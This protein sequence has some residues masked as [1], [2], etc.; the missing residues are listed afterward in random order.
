MEDGAD[1][2]PRASAEHRM[3]NRRCAELATGAAAAE[4]EEEV[5]YCFSASFAISIFIGSSRCAA[6]RMQACSRSSGLL[7]SP[8]PFQI[9]V[10]RLLAASALPDFSGLRMYTCPPS[11][12]PG[13][14]LPCG[15]STT[16][17]KPDLGSTAEM[18]TEV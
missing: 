8:S 9:M 13:L 14:A 6:Q 17:S 5:V 15:S 10:R 4:D 11:P 3:R 2:R 7:M 18:A 12:K 1:V 16:F